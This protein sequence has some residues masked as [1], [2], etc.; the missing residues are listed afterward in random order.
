MRPAPKMI[1]ISFR[2]SS[3]KDRRSGSSNCSSN[4]LP[5]RSKLIFRSPRSEPI[6]PSWLDRYSSALVPESPPSSWTTSW[7]SA[8]K[9]SSWLTKASSDAGSRRVLRRPPRS[10]ALALLHPGGGR[11]EL[12]RLFPGT[13]ATDEILLEEIQIAFDDLRP[14][15]ETRV[16]LDATDELPLS[17]VH[18]PAAITSSRMGRAR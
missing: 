18:R 14:Q 12:L 11:F 6:P 10:S 17:L 13:E 7:R 2:T 16:L 3:Q 1:T 15:V 9:V 5:R 4:Q 8:I